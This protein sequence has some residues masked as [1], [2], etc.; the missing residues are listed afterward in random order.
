MACSS[1]CSP[2]GLLRRYWSEALAG[3]RSGPLGTPHGSTPTLVASVTFL[4]LG[5]GFQEP[6]ATPLAALEEALS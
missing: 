4:S 6:W 5:P 1:G 3:T 2:C